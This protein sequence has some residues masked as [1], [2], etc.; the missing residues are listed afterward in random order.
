MALS[1]FEPFRDAH[2]ASQEPTSELSRLPALR[3]RTVGLRKQTSMTNQEGCLCV[4]RDVVAHAMGVAEALRNNSDRKRKLGLVGCDVL[5]FL[6]VG[7]AGWPSIARNRRAA[8]VGGAA[9]AQ[10][11]QPRHTSNGTALG[12]SNGRGRRRSVRRRR[13]VRRNARRCRSRGVG[14]TASGFQPPLELGTRHALHEFWHKRAK[15]NNTSHRNEETPNERTF[16]TRWEGAAGRGRGT[17][18]KCRRGYRFH[19]LNAIKS[20]QNSA[21][22]KITTQTP[23]CCTTAESAWSTY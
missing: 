7:N 23:A 21:K 6:H 5:W 13:C 8:L 19:V 11:R 17:K 3:R 12:A 22:K 1:T 9:A 4:R 20:T 14:A 2:N 18:C 15:L 10:R 16:G